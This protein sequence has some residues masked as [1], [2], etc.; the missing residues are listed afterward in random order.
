[1][2]T[3]KKFAATLFAT[4]VAAS[5]NAAVTNGG[6]NSNLSGWN[7]PR[8]TE[9]T[10]FGE[11]EGRGALIADCTTKRSITQSQTDL[12]I[13]DTYTLSYFLKNKV[14]LGLGLFDR[15]GSPEF[16]ASLGGTTLQ[17][18]KPND[19]TNWTEYKFDWTA[20]SS[21]ADLVFSFYQSRLFNYW[22]LDDVKLTKADV[23][24]P[25]V[26]ALLGLGALGLGLT[27]RKRIMKTNK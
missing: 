12:T 6:F 13:G 27:G 25:G 9:V 8:C 2:T 5:A 24:E 15:A 23:P 14:G 3:I 17:T 22:L 21:T 19:D 1:M 4:L 26:L 20:T 10:T 7:A 16:T 18:F 11:Y